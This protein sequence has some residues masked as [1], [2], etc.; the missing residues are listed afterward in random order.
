MYIHTLRPRSLR[1]GKRGIENGQKK[2]PYLYVRDTKHGFSANG[3]SGKHLNCVL[4][5]F[6]ALN[7]FLNTL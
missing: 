1:I 2:K 3:I 4:L 7:L 5:F 6:Y